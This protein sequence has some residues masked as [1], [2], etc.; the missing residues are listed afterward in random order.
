MLNTQDKSKIL[1]LQRQIDAIV[2]E[3]KKRPSGLVCHICGDGDKTTKNGIVFKVKGVVSRYERRPEQS[4]H[5][6][7]KHNGGWS[8][9]IESFDPLHQRYAEEINLHYA[10][11]VAKQLLKESRSKNV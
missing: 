7:H 8:L 10:S 11:Y 4:P 9:S 3:A 1:A 2:Q 6:C 5:L